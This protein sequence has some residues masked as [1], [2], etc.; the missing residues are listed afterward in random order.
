MR[1]CK[2]SSTCNMQYESCPV[3]HLLNKSP[4][5]HLFCSPL[6]PAP[7]FPSPSLSHSTR[8]C[9]L[10]RVRFRTYHRAKA[11]TTPRCVILPLPVHKSSSCFVA[12][13]AI[14]TSSSRAATVSCDPNCSKDWVVYASTVDSTATLRLTTTFNSPTSKSMQDRH[15]PLLSTIKHC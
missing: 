1:K 3:E 10:D 9:N 14:Q 7:P 13:L 6:F 11:V 4:T 12:K 5:D 8:S 15:Y 2:I